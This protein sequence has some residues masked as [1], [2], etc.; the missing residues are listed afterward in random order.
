MRVFTRQ[1]GIPLL[2]WL[3]KSV[4]IHLTIVLVLLAG[5]SDTKAATLYVTDYGATPSTTPYG[6]SDDTAGFNAAIQAA[7]PGD[8]IFV[9]NGYYNISDTININKSNITFKG[10]NRNWVGICFT[11]SSGKSSPV[12]MLQ[13][14]SQS[15]VTIYGICLHGWNNTDTTKGI[16]VRNSQR[17]LIDSVSVTNIPARTSGD[18]SAYGILFNWL[19]TDSVITDN[20]VRYIG[21]TSIWG[22]G[23]RLS[24]SSRNKILNNNVNDTGR[25]GI[26]ANNGSTDLIIEG[27]TVINSGVT[28]P[29]LGIELHWGNAQMQGSDRS[30]IQYNTVDHWI[31]VAGG[32]Q[33]AVRYNLVGVGATQIKSYGLEYGGTTDLILT[34]NTVD[35]GQYSGISLAN[36]GGVSTD[37]VYVANNVVSNMEAWGAELQGASDAPAYRMYFYA[38]TFENT[39]AQ[40]WGGTGFRL[41]GHCYNLDMDSNSFINNMVNGVQFCN[42]TVDQV[43]AVGN[44]I[45]GNDTRSSSMFLGGDLLWQD[46]AVY[47]NG[48]NYE[49][50][51]CGTFGNNQRPVVSIVEPQ[52]V[53]VGTP[54]TFSYNIVDD[55]TVAHVLWDFDEGIGLTSDSPTH[56][57]TQTGEYPV[58]LVVWD[59][60]GR[61]AHARIIITVTGP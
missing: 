13:I 40:P 47:G 42:S 20:L 54:V 53:T 61:A 30:L 8:T 9:S 59:D 32:T 45:T 41:V 55:G 39:L 56:T 1:F 24:Q 36:G 43:T 16:Y 7:S 50:A 48:Y 51:S 37:R 60:G 18:T 4:T 35:G 10:A 44:L 15:D 28:G 57:F 19:V 29:G 52:N 11:G 23:I 6:G 17:V 5:I 22:Q 33:I 49:P 21:R 27:N 26:F 3:L 46:N 34:N 31:S 2:P 25:G 38:N 12:P 14:D 58:S